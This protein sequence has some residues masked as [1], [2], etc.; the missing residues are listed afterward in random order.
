MDTKRKAPGYS[1]A[2]RVTVT[3]TAQTV[4]NANWTDLNTLILTN[5]GTA[6][7]F[8]NIGATATTTLGYPILPNSQQIITKDPKA[9]SLSVIGSTTGSDLHAMGCVSGI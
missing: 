2:S 9:T 3:G 5:I 7:L 1:S 8:V 4:T 6:V